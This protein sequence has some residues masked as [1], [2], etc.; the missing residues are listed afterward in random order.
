MS[1]NS[2]SPTRRGVLLAS[3]AAGLIIAGAL[4]SYVAL[5]QAPGIGR[6]DLVQ[7]D[8]SIAGREVVQVL[9]EIA[10]GVTAPRHSHPGEEIAYVL[11]GSLT[12]A[13]DGRP[14]VTL[15][16][17]DALFIPYGTFH[18]VKNVGSGKAVELATYIVE[19]GKPLLT[20]AEE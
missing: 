3:A 16:A 20:L 7:S 2:S 14:P 9:V 11:E 17:G 15:N 13:L 12:Y 6:T 10:P 8:L 1:Q 5:A 18:E 19:K 4:A